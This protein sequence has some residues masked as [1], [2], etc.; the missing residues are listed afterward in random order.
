MLLNLLRG[1]GLDGLSALRRSTRRPLLDLRR[2]ET[3]AVCRGAGLSWFDDPSNADRRFR[4]N[5]VRH[6]VLPLLTSVAE[7]D[8]VPVLCRQADL[9]ADDADLLAALAADLDPS[10]AAALA[11]APAPLARRAVRRWLQAASDDGQPPSAAAVDRVLA[12]A[13]GEVVACEV[14]GGRRVARTAGRLRLEG[15]C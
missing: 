15:P 9:L 3:E 1:A 6:E 11:A 13:R 7:R 5:R 2:R 8:L 10:D 4:R 14:R 12:V